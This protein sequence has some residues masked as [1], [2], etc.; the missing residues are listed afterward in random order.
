MSGESFQ[1]DLGYRI[2]G[3]WLGEG[4]NVEDVG[5]FRILGSGAGPEKALG[6]GAGVQDAL[7]PRRVK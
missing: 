5:G 6:T 4:L 1:R 3:E 2:H 7:P